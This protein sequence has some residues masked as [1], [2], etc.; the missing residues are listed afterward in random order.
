[1]PLARDCSFGLRNPSSSRKI[2]RKIGTL[3]QRFLIGFQQI[4][5]GAQYG[6]SMYWFF[7]HIWGDAPEIM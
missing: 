3:F 1:M 2:A 4:P 5:G 7:S 6:W